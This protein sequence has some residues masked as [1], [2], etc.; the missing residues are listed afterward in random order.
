MTRK[1]DVK[2]TL[3]GTVVEDQGQWRPLL[4]SKGPG[5]EVTL[6]VRRGDEEVELTCTLGRRGG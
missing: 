4:Q 6:T 1:D 2:D 3:H 5:D